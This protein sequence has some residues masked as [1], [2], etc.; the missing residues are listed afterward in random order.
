M[1]HLVALIQF[2]PTRA[3]GTQPGRAGAA[4]LRRSFPFFSVTAGESHR[5]A[6]QTPVNLDALNEHRARTCDAVGPLRRVHDILCQVARLTL[7]T[8]YPLQILILGRYLD[9]RRAEVS[10]SQA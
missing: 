7:H 1:G 4:D 5:K 6:S 9:R 3:L 10:H 8:P 2:I